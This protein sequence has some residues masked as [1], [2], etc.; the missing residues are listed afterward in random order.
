MEY[1]EMTA[2]AAKVTGESKK[3]GLGVEFN[4]RLKLNFMDRR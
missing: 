2:K 1:Q 4:G 3:Q